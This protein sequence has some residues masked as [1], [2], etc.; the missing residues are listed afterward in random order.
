MTNLSEYIKTQ[1]DRP[2]REWAEMFDISRPH[3]LALIEGKRAP[4]VAVARRIEEQTQGAVPITAWPN[5][6]AMMRALSGDA[7]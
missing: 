2:M 1:P 3:L 6:A 5:I 7:A 4:S